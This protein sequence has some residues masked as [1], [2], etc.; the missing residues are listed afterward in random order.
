MIRKDEIVWALLDMLPGRGG[1]AANWTMPAKAAPVYA[2]AEAPDFGWRAEGK[3]GYESAKYSPA[4][5]GYYAPP[6]EMTQQEWVED[7]PMK[8]ECHHEKE[9]CFCEP[10]PWEEE[11]WI[12]TKESRI[13]CE[14][15]PCKKRKDPGCGCAHG[16]WCDGLW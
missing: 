7:Y 2:P 1:R 8:E 14:K 13:C 12:C 3:G 10:W 15:I 6:P 4:G 11:K 9:E 16:Y 5:K